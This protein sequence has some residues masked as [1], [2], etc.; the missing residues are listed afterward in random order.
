MVTYVW[1]HGVT[2]SPGVRQ[3]SPLRPPGW[4]PWTYVA[5]YPFPP[6]HPLSG[7]RHPLSRV[8]W[9]DG[10]WPAVIVDSDW[11]MYVVVRTDYRG[12]WVQYPH[13]WWITTVDGCSTPPVPSLGTYV[14]LW[15]RTI[16]LR[17]CRYVRS[18]LTYPKGTYVVYSTYSVLSYRA[19][20]RVK[21]NYVPRKVRVYVQVY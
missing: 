17:T 13:C 15:V 14:P 18:T 6:Y 7:E 21:K 8:V 3:V 20:P 16:T 9:R 12:N 5:Q 11:G 4:P 19:L 10:L 2:S 1:G